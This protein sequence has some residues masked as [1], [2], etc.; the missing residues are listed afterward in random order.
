[1]RILGFSKKWDKL[2]RTEFTTFRYPRKDRDWEINEIVQAVYK[3][4]SKNREILGMA[5]IIKKELRAMAL[6]GDKT[7][8]PHITNEEAIADGFPDTE[9]QHGY[10]SMWEFLWDYYGG[11]RLISEPMNKLTL[12][13]LD[14]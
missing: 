2:K 14:R 10:F 12:K 4:R 9:V 6:Q 13:W 7:G 5:Q 8:M 11:E 1:M 3:P